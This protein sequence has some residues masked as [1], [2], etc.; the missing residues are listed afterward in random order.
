[1]TKPSPTIGG[2]DWTDLTVPDAEPVRTF[3]ERVVGWSSEPFDMG[4]YSDHCMKDASGKTVAGICHGKGENAGLPAQWL[5]Y[6]NVA[7]LDASL[8]AVAELGGRVLREPR[9]MGGGSRMA[10]IEDPA[11]AV[12]ALFQHGSDAVEPAG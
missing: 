7:D 4:G 10:V 12:C 2:I 9:S 3:Y 5:V 11:G 6:L 1:M 8:C